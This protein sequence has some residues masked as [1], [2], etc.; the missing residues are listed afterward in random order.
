MSE[1]E[2]LILKTLHDNDLILAN[3]LLKQYESE[4]INQ[5]SY[6]FL[7]ACFFIKK[8]NLTNGWL[9]LWRGLE[10]FPEDKKL[11][12][13]MWMISQLLGRRGQ[14]QVYKEKKEL[15]NNNIEIAFQLPFDL[16][17]YEKVNIQS[18]FSVL[19]GSMEI[20]NQMNTLSQG[21]KRLGIS[22]HTL[23]YY[24]YYLNYVSDY[25]WSLIGQ[26][27]TPTIN[28]QLRKLTEEFLLNYDVFHFH[29]GTSLTLDWSDIPILKASEKEIVMQHWGSDVRL[30]S[31]AKKL[32]PYAL[33]KNANEDLI[34]WNLQKLSQ[35]IKHCV[36]FDM[37]LY[38]YVKDYYENVSVIP[39]MVDMDQYQPSVNEKK[40]NK[41]LI[42]HAPTSPYIKGTQYI[43]KAIESLKD[44]YNFDFITVQGKSHEEAIQ[45][46][47]EADLIIDQLHI[48]S[49][50]LF[51][52]ETMAMSKPVICWISDYMK[53]N[54]PKD[55]PIIIANPDTIKDC[56]ENALKNLDMLPE[57]GKRGRA[58]VE[59]NHDMVKN[60]K[61]ML[62]LYRTIQKN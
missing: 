22:S 25:E 27:S 59:K 23:N 2:N 57:I 28:T 21:L 32:N 16:D 18:S 48:G 60:S 58:Y 13:L 14:E 20:A 42:A 38:H 37:E 49:Y 6:Y 39:A 62:S 34:K 35:Q 33:V 52:I 12:Y 43:L 47:R 10:L 51:A 50:G 15:L 61:Q 26:R 56:I 24:P 29:W 54:Y 46:Y 7:N 3:K 30:I 19:Q 17:S 40:K 44:Q 36:V 9:W 53:E 5:S 4:Q 55:L 8:G 31:E 1:K 41:L 45:I 11:L